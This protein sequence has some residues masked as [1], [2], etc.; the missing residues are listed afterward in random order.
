MTSPTYTTARP[1]GYFDRRPMRDC[2]ADGAAQYV[3][4]HIP[5]L[6]AEV[7]DL[8]QDLT[9]QKVRLEI[10]NGNLRARNNW[11]V[12][13]MSQIRDEAVADDASDEEFREAAFRLAGRAIAPGIGGDA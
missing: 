1:R 7:L 5:A 4:P 11:L 2:E 3:D 10:E 6:P 9:T 13:T 12:R 8:I